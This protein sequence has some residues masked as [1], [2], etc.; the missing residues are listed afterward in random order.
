MSFYVVQ[1]SLIIPL[2]SETGKDK[3]DINGTAFAVKIIKIT[4]QGENY[5]I[6]FR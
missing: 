2:D 3:H 5:E 6:L 1:R 4:C